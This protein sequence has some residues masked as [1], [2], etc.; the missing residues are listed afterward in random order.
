MSYQKI[1]SENVLLFKLWNGRWKPVSDNASIDDIIHPR[2][3]LEFPALHLWS[4]PR[5]FPHMIPELN[6][7][8]CDDGL[9]EDCWV[10]ITNS[11]EVWV[12][13]HS[14]YEHS[15]NPYMNPNINWQMLQRWKKMF[16]S[17][18]LRGMWDCQTRWGLRYCRHLHHQQRQSIDPKL[19]MRRRGIFIHT[20]AF[21]I[22]LV[23][24]LK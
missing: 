18:I 17:V 8:L 15:S 4:C 21:F 13:Q 19:F 23:M 2:A 22:C 12:F 10:N 24:S 5:C 7:D 6:G 1:C 3:L 20:C 11:S 16:E 9:A 14:V